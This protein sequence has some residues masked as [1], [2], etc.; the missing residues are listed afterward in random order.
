MI[1][2]EDECG[3]LLT[4]NAAELFKPFEQQHAN[5]QGLG[6][7]LTIA[8]KAIELNLGTIKA[9]NLPG[10]GCIFTITL[11]NHM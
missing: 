7:G 1:E 10:K 8:Q 3:G 5:K 11:P 2:V 9:K 4:T 6:L